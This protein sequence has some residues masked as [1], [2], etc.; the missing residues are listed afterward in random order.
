MYIYANELYPVQ[1]AG[2]GL[3][4]ACIIGSLPN[5]IIPSL[6][7][8]ANNNNFPFMI[9]FCIGSVIGIVSILPLR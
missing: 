4:F 6:I 5:V 8:L 1:V 3:S 9:L 2:L 7:N